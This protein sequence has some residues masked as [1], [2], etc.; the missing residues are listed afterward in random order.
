MCEAL[1]VCVRPWVCVC[2]AVGVCQTSA[3]GKK[4][5]CHSVEVEMQMSLSAA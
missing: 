2:G 1:G 5:F 4:G 3:G